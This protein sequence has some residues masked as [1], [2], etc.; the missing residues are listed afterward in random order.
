MADTRIAVPLHIGGDSHV[1]L[2]MN[3]TTEAVLRLLEN[4]TDADKIISSLSEVYDDEEKIRRCVNSV[5][6]TLRNEDLL[7][8]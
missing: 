5:L 1:V 7:I 8:E 6:E 2:Q 3:S 4:D